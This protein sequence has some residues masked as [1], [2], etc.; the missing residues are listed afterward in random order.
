MNIN[1]IYIKKNYDSVD[2][3]PYGSK[4]FK[5]SPALTYHA[6]SKLDIWSSRILGLSVESFNNEMYHQ[7]ASQAFKPYPAHEF[8]S[9]DTLK[10]S[11][12]DAHLFRTIHNRRSRRMYKL[13]YLA[14]KELYF[15]CHYAYGISAKTELHG[16]DEGH[17][18]YRNVPSGGGL[19]PLEIYPVVFSA[20]CVPGVYHYRPDKNGLELLQKDHF[21]ETINKIITAEPIVNLANACAVIFVSGLFERVMIKYGE[22]GYRFILQETGFVA[23][24]ISLVCEAIGLGSCMIGGFLDDEVN[25]LLGLDGVT[26]TVLNVIVIGK[27]A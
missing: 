2:L 7:R 16:L 10:D 6:F 8:I 18:Y 19:Y 23:Q 20:E 27:P 15:L 13:H 21:Y 24:N 22:R 17:W 11:P 4:N 26:E 5:D 1:E 3:G 14:L 9:F 25:N 12:P